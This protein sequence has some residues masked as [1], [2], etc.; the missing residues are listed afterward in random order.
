M[1][2]NNDE[3][4]RKLVLKLSANT[5]FNYSLCLNLDNHLVY[6]HV[7]RCV[8]V[9]LSRIIARTSVA[10][11]ILVLGAKHVTEREKKEGRITF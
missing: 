6:A 9:S 2:I 4:E 7:C 3:I 5:L 8:C 10:L 11:I 1:L